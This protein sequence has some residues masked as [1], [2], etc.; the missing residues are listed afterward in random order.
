MLSR[1]NLTLFIFLF[2]NVLLAQQRASI[3]PYPVLN[4]LKN[5]QDAESYFFERA[6]FVLAD[7]LFE[8]VYQQLPENQLEEKIYVGLRRAFTLCNL[9]KAD[10]ALVYLD[11]LAPLI[12]KEGKVNELFAADLY[13]YKAKAYARKGVPREALKWNDMAIE[14]KKKYLDATDPKMGESYAVYT[15][16]HNYYTM[17]IQLAGDYLMKEKE[18]I[19]AHPDTYPKYEQVAFHYSISSYYSKRREY[20]K[21]S[22]HGKNAIRVLEPF[23]ELHSNYMA[24]CYALM[25]TAHLRMTD[26][27]PAIDYF[28]KSLEYHI[29]RKERYSSD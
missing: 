27:E 11:Q 3:S 14:I 22:T 23:E 4:D 16:V 1:T 24:N 20:L 7:Q 28:E 18:V 17:Q 6:D 19:K 5:F 2:V 10:D 12:P 8:E 26:P 21:A 9:K 13:T 15:Y 25:G 29:G